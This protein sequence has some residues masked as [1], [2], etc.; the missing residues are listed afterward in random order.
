MGNFLQKWGSYGSDP[1]Q[2]MDPSGIA[3]DKSGNVLVTDTGNSRV[4]IFDNAGNF[5]RHLGTVGTGNGQFVNPEGIAIDENGNIFV[6]DSGNSRIQVFDGANNFLRKWGSAGFSNG[7]F[8]HPSGIAVDVNGNVFVADVGNNRI[9]AFNSSGTFLRKW[10]SLGDAN[11]FFREPR[12]VAV[13]KSGARV[14]VADSGNN[15]IQVFEGYGAARYSISG[16]VR[17]GSSTGPVLAGATVAIAGLTATTNSTGTFS[18][19]GI[20]AGTY[21]LTVSKTGY[22]TKTTTGYVV[23]SNKSGLVFYLSAAPRYSMSGTVR[24]GSTTG[25]VLAGATVAIAGKTATTSSTGT[26]SIT[27]ILAGTYTLTI[28]KTGYITKTTTGYVVNSNKSGLVFYLSAAPRYSMSGTVRQGSTTGPVLAGATVA[29]AGKTATTSSTGTF[30]ITGILAGTY[31]L[32]ISKTGYVTKTTTGYLV[33]SN[34]SGLIFYLSAAPGYTMRGA[35]DR[36]DFRLPHVLGY[37]GG[38]TLMAALRNT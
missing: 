14:Y 13:D 24:Q 38:D 23:N 12:G 28:S 27:G 30:S 35:G 37:L 36:L 17:Q 1:G 32:T 7:L 26:F 21:T 10:G 29:I 22:I 3:V 20:L 4:E 6:V 2:L 33:N 11:A 31:T 19:T 15:R 18:I 25:P 16:T 5:L 8:S 9:Q 34:K